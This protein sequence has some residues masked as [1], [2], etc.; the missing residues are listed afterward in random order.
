[1]I[2]PADAQR[3]ALDLDQCRQHLQRIQA[4]A[5]PALEQK[6]VAV[7]SREYADTPSDPDVM[8]YSG[9]FFSQKDKIAMQKIRQTPPQKLAN[10]SANFDD[11]RLPEMLFRYRGRNYPHTLNADESQDWLRFCRERLMSPDS[12]SNLAEFNEN[13]RRLQSQPGANQQLL[14][15]LEEFAAAKQVLL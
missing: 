2:R 13:L 6:L 7:F 5:G 11:A 10:F 12:A 9:G 4:A 15:Q 1:V 3:L 8:I 14:T